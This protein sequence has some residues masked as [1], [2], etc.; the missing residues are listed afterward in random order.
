MSGLRCALRSAEAA[1]TEFD[2]S[3]ADLDSA[4]QDALDYGKEGNP[5]TCYKILK[6]AE[7]NENKKEF[8]IRYEVTA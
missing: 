2:M 7:K 5:I 4:I 6:S 8:S 3:V 1:L